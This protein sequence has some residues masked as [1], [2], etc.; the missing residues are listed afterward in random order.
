MQAAGR[1]ACA[2]PAAA[3]LVPNGRAWP[4]SHTRRPSVAPA[5]A[6]WPAWSTMR[7]RPNTWSSY[8]TTSLWFPWLPWWARCA[9][10]AS[11][12]LRLGFPRL[13]SLLLVLAFLAT[14]P[15]PLDGRAR[16]CLFSHGCLCPTGC[17]RTCPKPPT[18]CAL[19]SHVCSL[20]KHVRSLCV[21]GQN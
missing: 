13:S 1:R 19:A 18:S 14:M 9:C 17:A 16:A 5:R 21:R 7:T 3:P 8:G 4:D 10:T 6:R 15:K 2:G 20:P 12:W 11:S